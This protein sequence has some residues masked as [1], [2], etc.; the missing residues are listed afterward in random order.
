MPTPS[1]KEIVVASSANSCRK[2]AFTLIELLVVIAIIAILAAMLLPAL[3]KAKVKAQQTACRSNMKQVQ[4]ALIMFCNDNGDWLPPGS[5]G[6]GV[7]GLYNGFPGTYSTINNHTATYYLA[8]NCGTPGPTAVLQTNKVC[9]CPGYERYFNS[10]SVTNLL[11]Y[12]HCINGTNDDQPGQ[13]VYPFGYPS[14]HTQMK[15]TQ[16]TSPSTVWAFID[17]DSV[18][19]GNPASGVAD[20]PVH[21][22]S[23]NLS[24]FDGRVASKKVGPVGSY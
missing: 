8:P 12:Q 11:T 24:Y 19:T 14:T 9:I 20:K 22:A 5:P 23:R 13:W 16:I 4:L 10:A 21:G 6:D 1:K 3:A 7:I 15:V 18:S 2:S 17:Y